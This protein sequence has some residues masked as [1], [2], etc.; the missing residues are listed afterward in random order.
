[1]NRQSFL[2]NLTETEREKGN[3]SG[4]LDS[5]RVHVKIAA[6]WNRSI[7]SCAVNR[8]FGDMKMIGRMISGTIMITGLQQGHA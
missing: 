1:M 4:F 7:S 5:G 8:M 3:Q 6:N 2:K